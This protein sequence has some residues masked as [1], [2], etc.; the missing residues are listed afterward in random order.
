M[1]VSYISNQD[2]DV[3]RIQ[4]PKTAITVVEDSDDRKNNSEAKEDEDEDCDN[5]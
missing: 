1:R 2:S 5:H 4:K 3:R